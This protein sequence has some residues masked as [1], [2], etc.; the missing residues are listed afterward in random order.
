[1]C[2]FILLC[3]KKK[4]DIFYEPRNYRT[5]ELWKDV[6][7]E[8]WNDPKWQKKNS[9]RK[10]EQL[11]KVI[12]LNPL[13]EKEIARTLRT[14]KGQGKEPMRITPYYA[15]IMQADPFNPIMLPGEKQKKRLDPIFW[16]SVPTPANLL[17]PDTGAEGAMSED[18]RSY[19]AAYQRYP[20]RVALFV[21]ENTS[22]AS[23]CVHCQ[24][25]KSLDGTVEVSLNEI[26]KGLFYI[27]YNKNINEVLVTGGDA[28]MISNKRLSYILEELSRIPHLRVIRIATRVPVV[29]P[30]GI[31]DEVLELIK[32]ASNRYTEGPAKYVYFMTHINHYHEITKDLARAV[33]KILDH[34]FTIRNQ[35]VFLNH[36]NDYYKTLAETFRRMFWIGVHPYY[37]LQCHKEKGIVHFITPVQ[38]GKVFMKHLQGW[39]SGVTI[40][41]YAA[42]VEGGGGKVL[43]MPSGHDTLNTG[44]NIEKKISESFATV[45]TWDG[46]EIY[47]YEAL[48][49]ATRKEFDAAVKIMDEFIGRPGVFLP[50]VI[51]VDNEGRHIETTNRSNLPIHEK[52]KKSD[53]LEYAIYEN[54][55]PLT[56]PAEIAW[57]LDNQFEKSRFNS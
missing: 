20:N 52:F 55:M 47:R 45:T 46:K 38:V 57:E 54:D 10:V 15:S 4:N 33:E 31:T 22:C 19:G 51:I 12:K 43:L 6:S 36:V 18:T 9:I 16:Q 29:M 48:G 8:Q 49:R 1:L 25:A 41:R 53:L 42:N 28:L 23:Y 39:M 34:G 14:M 44:N 50:K 17:F 35:T 30:M 26:N 13:Q 11:K 21:A 40:P 37:L 7:P 5:I 2:L 3:M 56:N 27:G 24:R 32:S